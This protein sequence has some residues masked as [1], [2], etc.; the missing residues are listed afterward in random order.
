ME[1]ENVLGG[2]GTER[3]LANEVGDLPMVAQDIVI[4]NV[5]SSVDFLTITVTNPGKSILLMQEAQ[6][7]KGDLEGCGWAVK[8]W[9]MKGY[10]GYRIAGMAWG[11]GHDG[12]IMMLSGQDAAINWLPALALAENVTRLDLAATVA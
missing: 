9:G 6:R 11:V 5:A 8:K 2:N 7:L 10:S 4:D 12:R 1:P 3:S